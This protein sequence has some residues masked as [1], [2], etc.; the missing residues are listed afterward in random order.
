MSHYR[1]LPPVLDASSD[2][3]AK[4]SALHSLSA[5]NELRQQVLQAAKA[6]AHMASK[7]PIQAREKL[8]QTYALPILLIGVT[9]ATLGIWLFV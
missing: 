2:A 8:V 3:S 5:Q 9:L 7:L 6:Q 1:V 4:L